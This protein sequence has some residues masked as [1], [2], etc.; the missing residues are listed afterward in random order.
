MLKSVFSRAAAVAIMAGF[1]ALG[2]PGA[3]AKTSIGIWIG[4]PGFGYWYG[5]GYYHGHYRHRLT[6]AE[7]RWIVD[8][9]GYNRVIAIDCSPRYYRYRAKRGGHWWLVRLDS[10][11]GHI[12]GARP[13]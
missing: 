12:V 7:G 13:Y 6:C 10:R 5:P 1:L 9:R 3:E 4:V 8:H 2:A 11:T